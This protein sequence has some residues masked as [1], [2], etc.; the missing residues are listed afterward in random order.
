M[1]CFDIGG[2]PALA[3][4]STSPLNGLL[5]ASI[6]RHDV[7]CGEEDRAGHGVSPRF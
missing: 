3:K 5:V 2:A 1:S 4:F 7:V 6:W